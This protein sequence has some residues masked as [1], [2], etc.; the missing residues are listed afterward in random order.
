MKF[1]LMMNAPGGK[2]GDYAISNWSADD[3]KAHIAFMKTL[4]KDL[5]SAGE[6]V[7]AEGLAPPGQAR[8]GPPDRIGS[9]GQPRWF[10]RRRAI[11]HGPKIS[12]QRGEQETE[13][14]SGHNTVLVALDSRGLKVA[15]DKTIAL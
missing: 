1:M 13:R 12:R 8:Q 15:H 7:G 10:R 5:S 6:L 4:H 14:C 11:R 3:F 9:D 2:T